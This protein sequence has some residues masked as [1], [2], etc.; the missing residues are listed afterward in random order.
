MGTSW[1]VGVLVST[2]TFAKL[3]YSFFCSL[4]E[5]SEESFD[6][7]LEGENNRE[8]HCWRLMAGG[9]FSHKRKSRAANIGRKMD[10]PFYCLRLDSWHCKWNFLVGLGKGHMVS[11]CPN[12]RTMAVLVNGVITSASFSGSSSSCTESAGQCD[13][14]PLKGDLLMVRR[15]IGSVC[16]DW[17]E[18]QRENIFHTRCMVMG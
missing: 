5:T 17:D 8:H 9:V 1:P 12:K 16:K 13:V 15:L 2:L 10:E 4:R 11:Q 3:P 7:R 6:W 14:Q 18:T